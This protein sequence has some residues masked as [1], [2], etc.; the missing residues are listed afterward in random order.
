MEVVGV[1]MSAILEHFFC[2][3]LWCWAVAKGKWKTEMKIKV[4]FV[5]CNNVP[6]GASDDHC[7]FLLDS[8]QIEATANRFER[9]V[10]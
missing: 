2:H 9:I 6:Q 5:I 4:P 1:T 7:E 3:L 8:C 10:I